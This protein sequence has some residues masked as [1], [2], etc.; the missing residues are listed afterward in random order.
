MTEMEITWSVIIGEGARGEW[1]QRY[2]EK[3]ELVGTK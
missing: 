2:M 3:E 1:G